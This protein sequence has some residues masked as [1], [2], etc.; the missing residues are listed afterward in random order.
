[1]LPYVPLLS[2]QRATAAHEDAWWAA[3]RPTLL[4]FRGNT[5]LSRCGELALR[6]TPY[7]LDRRHPWALPGY[8]T[9]RARLIAAANTTSTGGAYDLDLSGVSSNN[10]HTPSAYSTDAV[11]DGMR[12]ATFCLAPR[13]DTG[14]SRRIYDA[15]MAGCIPILVADDIALPF[16]TTLDWHTFSLRVDEAAA[17]GLVPYLR[18]MPQPRIAALRAGVRRARDQ[19]LFIESGE[20]F[21]PGFVPGRASEL[22]LHAIAAAANRPACDGSAGVQRLQSRADIAPGAPLMT[23]SAPWW[24]NATAADEVLCAEDAA[25][26]LRRAAEVTALAEQDEQTRARPPLV[27]QRVRLGRLETRAELNGEIGVAERALDGR[28]G[29][30]VVRLSGNGVRCLVSANHLMVASAVL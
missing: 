12:R 1:M 5:E 11:A 23:V 19:L 13:G 17:E 30:L 15:I 4:Y 21:T 9:L 22:V 3:P 16:T 29:W 7:S 20:P 14:S 28:E 27:G 25:S 26:E 6:R 8:C 18:A 24:A 2:L 10:Q